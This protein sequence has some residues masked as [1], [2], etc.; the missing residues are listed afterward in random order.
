MALDA[1]PREP[2][3]LVLVEDDLGDAKAVRRSFA[4]ARLANP[5]VHLQDG[6]EALE[7][8]RGAEAPM[9][10]LLLVDVNMPRMNGIELIREIRRDPDLHRAVVFVLTTSADARDVTA[11]YDLNVAGYILKSCVG[12][13]FRSLIGALDGFWQIVLL[14]RVGVPRETKRG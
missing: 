7:Y 14:P 5:I 12:D 10:F 11:A 6:V 8:L 9:S 4:K 3:S 2:V 13:D 1:P